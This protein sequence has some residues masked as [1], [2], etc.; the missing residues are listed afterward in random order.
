MKSLKDFIRTEIQEDGSPDTDG[1]GLLS[2]S[3]L[4]QHLDIQKRGKVDLAD[5]AA[6]VMFHTHHPEYLAHVVPTFND[7]QKRHSE[8]QEL[9]EHDPVMNKLKNNASLVATD[10][11][12]FEGKEASHSDE[13]PPPILMMRRKSIRLF[14]NGQK[15]ALYYIDKLNKYVSIPYSSMMALVPEETV[16][17]KIKVV[18]ETKQTVVVEHLDGSTTEVT[19]QVAD[20]IMNLYKKINETNK[21]KLADMLEASAKHFQTIVK[22]SK[23]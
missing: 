2:P 21:E 4:H 3:E 9:C 19:P 23:E 11:P 6:H 13:D 12:M 18:K 5:Y 7:I 20:S 8:G 15:V 16:F 14:P 22:F 10:Y 17:D 1:D